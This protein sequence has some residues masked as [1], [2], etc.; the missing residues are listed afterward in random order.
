MDGA[1]EEHLKVTVGLLTCQTDLQM[2]Q[3]HLLGV[4]SWPDKMLVCSK[5]HFETNI[6]EP[7]MDDID[8]SSVLISCGKLLYVR[9][10]VV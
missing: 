7:L 3:A 1:E 2:E 9:L 8:T 5:L 6:P 10:L 4:K